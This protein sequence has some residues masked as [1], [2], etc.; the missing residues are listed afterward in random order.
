VAEDREGFIRHWSEL[1]RPDDGDDPGDCDL[2]AIGAP[3]GRSG[4]M[5]ARR[6]WGA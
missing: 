5:T 3:L 2:L 6:G 4:R 1:E